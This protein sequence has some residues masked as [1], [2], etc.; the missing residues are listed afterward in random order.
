MNAEED[1]VDDD[2]NNDG[3]LEKEN[4][5]SKK[6]AASKLQEGNKNKN[7]AEIDALVIASERGGFINYTKSHIDYVDLDDYDK[8]DYAAYMLKYNVEH[9]KEIGYGAADF[10]QFNIKDLT[11]GEGFAKLFKLESP[12]KTIM[13]YMSLITFLAFCTVILMLL[14]L[15]VAFIFQASTLKKSTIFWMIIFLVGMLGITYIMDFVLNNAQDKIENIQYY[16]K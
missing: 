9:Q 6:I 4:S 12:K 7:A 3:D 14:A 10:A 15:L 11:T 2:H 1:Y 8:M 5:L 13:R 16:L